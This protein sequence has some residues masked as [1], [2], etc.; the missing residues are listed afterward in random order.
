M[1]ADDNIILEVLENLLSNAIR[2]AKTEIEVISEF[3][4]EKT[5]FLLAV[6]DDGKGFSEEQLE[7]AP[8]PYYKEYEGV[9]MDEH[10]GI[11]L[12]ICK[13]FCKKHGGTLS[14]SNSIRGGAVVT[15]SFFAPVFYKNSDYS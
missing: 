11:G 10:F 9:E 5:E 8:K 12:H 6:R 13:E 14:V 3:D 2:Y 1:Q 15:A 7:K 4:E